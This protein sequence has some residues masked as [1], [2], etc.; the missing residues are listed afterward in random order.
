MAAGFR[1]KVKRAYTLKGQR[2]LIL[3]K[4]LAGEVNGGEWIEVNLPSGEHQRARVASVAWGSAFHAEDSPLT[5][6]VEG[7]SDH[8]PAPGDEVRGSWPPEG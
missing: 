8:E 6:V 7:L 3:E 1:G 2:V 4:D 5:L